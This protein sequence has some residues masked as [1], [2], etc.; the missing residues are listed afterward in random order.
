MLL[1]LL[2]NVGFHF[3]LPNQLIS[4]FFEVAMLPMNELEYMGIMEKLAV[5]EKKFVVRTR[6]LAA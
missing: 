1:D 3:V 6:S 4:A 2:K 5:F